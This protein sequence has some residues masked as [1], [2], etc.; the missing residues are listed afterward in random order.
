MSQLGGGAGDIAGKITKTLIAPIIVGF[1]LSIG[2][3]LLS[4]M[5]NISYGGVSGYIVDAP[6]SNLDT[7]QDLLI[8]MGSVVFVWMGV[9]AAISDAIGGS[10]AGTIMTGAKSAGGWLAKA[11]FMYTPLF[12]IK[13]P[14]STHGETSTSAHCSRPSISNVATSSMGNIKRQRSSWNDGLRRWQRSR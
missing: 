13:S 3:I 11:P 10:I 1:V 2:Y 8:A 12:Q 4:T 7:F 14:H 6:V 5:Q 9:E